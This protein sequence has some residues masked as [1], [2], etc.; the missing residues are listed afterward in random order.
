MP[1]RHSIGSKAFAPEALQSMYEAFDPAWIELAPKHDGEERRA[2]HLLGT[3]LH[4][5]YSRQA[6]VNIQR[7]WSHS[8]PRR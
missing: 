5:R 8:K 1:F 4:V 3:C 6:S 7:M 2:S